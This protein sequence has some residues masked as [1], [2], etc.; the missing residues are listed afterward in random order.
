MRFKTTLFLLASLLTTSMF[1]QSPYGNIEDKGN[2]FINQRQTRTVNKNVRFA[3]NAFT[4]ALQPKAEAP[5]ELDSSLFVQPEGEL[6]LMRRSGTD[7]LPVWGQP[8]PADYEEKGT[9]VVKGTDG[10]YYF[11]NFVTNM[12]NGGTWVKGE[13]EGN[14]ISVKTGQICT[15]L[16]YDNGATNEVYTYYLHG[17]KEQEEVGVDWEGNEYTYTVFV[18]DEDVTEIKFNIEADGSLTSQDGNLLYGGLEENEDGTY[19]WPGYGDMNCTFYPFDEEPQTAPEEVEFSD[20]VFSNYPYATDIE[21]RILEGGILDNVLYVKGLAEIIPEAVIKAQIDGDKARIETNQFLGVDQTYSTLVYLKPCSYTI[22]TD[23]WGWSTIYTDEVSEMIMDYDAEA[24]R[25]SN[26]ELGLLI[27][28]GKMEV[29]THEQ[30]LRPTFYRFEETP[31]TP[32]DPVWTQYYPYTE[33]DFG[34]WGYAGFNIYPSDVDDNYILPDKLFYTCY[35][36]E[37][38]LVF[39]T[40]D[41]P[42]LEEDMTVIPY[43]FANNDIVA[44]KET[45]YVYFHRGDFDKFG[46]QT[47]YRGGGEERRSPIVYYAESG[48]D[49]AFDNN[50]TV[51][52]TAYYDLQGHRHNG[53]NTGLN[54]VVMKYSNGTTKSTKVMVR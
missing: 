18:L 20:F 39:S 2:A 45:H 1:A 51:I 41:Y 36:D 50:A 17:L 37:T 26:D 5:T 29:L 30:Y 8:A 54:I 53:L 12:C 23:E 21:Y 9:Y 16:W 44:Y 11:K 32:S 49:E 13:V 19:S 48:V 22:E 46:V 24:C 47:I 25:F 38:P 43:A 31:A 52:E 3:D 10:N 40:E 28:A 34:S 42:E 27:N 7:Y 4:M 33:A 15:Q 6:Q 14:V 35:L